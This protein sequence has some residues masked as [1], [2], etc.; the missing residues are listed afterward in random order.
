[1]RRPHG[2]V[3]FEVEVLGQGFGPP[4]LK[5]VEHVLRN[6]GTAA[7]LATSFANFSYIGVFANNLVEPHASLDLMQ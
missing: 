4:R 2:S 5:E 3:V 6:R 1:M 7:Y